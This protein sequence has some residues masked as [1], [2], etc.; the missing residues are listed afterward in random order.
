MNALSS[1]TKTRVLIL[2]GG[3][4][5]SA[6]AAALSQRPGWAERISVLERDPTYA[7]ASSALSAASIRQQ[8]STPLNIA[9][10]QY[11]L[12]T[13]RA[14]PQAQ[15][16]ERGYLYLATPAGRAR[17]EALHSL[18]RSQG[19]SIDLLKPTQL[20]ERWP[21]LATQDLSLGSWGR[22]GEGWFD[23]W[24]LLQGLRS[25]AFQAGVRYLQGEAVALRTEPGS[26]ALTGVESTLGFLQADVYVL[27]CGAWSGR[28]AATAG[29]AVPVSAKRRSVYGFRSPEV[30]AGC[31]L[32]IDP[33][34][35]WFRPEGDQFICGGPPLGPDEDDLP[36]EPEPDLFEQKLWPAL[37]ERVPG[38]E[39][40]R[41]TRAWAGYYEMNSFDHNGLVGALDTC[42]NLL[43]A[44]GF[45]GHGLQHAAGVGRGLAEWLELGRYQTLDLSPLS[46]NR[47]AANTPVVELN[48]I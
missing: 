4:M 35:L 15:L 36:L 30:A 5:G 40:L 34:G 41:P 47:I 39:S 43:L 44:C 33:S 17:Q 16:Q 12:Q 20:R 45:S 19:A 13:L 8:F 1:S 27:A 21:W 6:L 10:S 28:L 23:G 32:V 38:F 11:G 22:S 48:V 14:Q 2:G 9:L 42:P 29:L 7:R 46:A 26:G 25:Q 24:G 31:P 37:A 18:Q 3:A